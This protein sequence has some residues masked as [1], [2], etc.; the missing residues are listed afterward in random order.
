MGDGLRSP[1]GLWPGAKR[2][3]KVPGMHKAKMPCAFAV[4][5]GSFWGGAQ[6]IMA[7]A[8]EGTR[9]DKMTE[10]HIDF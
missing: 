9:R 3:K 8:Q 2:R 1:R 4:P 7:E 5:K 10:T 6:P